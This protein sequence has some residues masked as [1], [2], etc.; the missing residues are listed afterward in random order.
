MNIGLFKKPKSSSVATTLYFAGI[1]VSSCALYLL[2][3]RPSQITQEETYCIVGIT[4]LIGIVAINLVARS[5]QQTVV[6][7]DRKKE[8]VTVRQGDSVEDNSQ[9]DMGAI[10]KIVE[11]GHEIPQTVINEL[12]HQ[13]QAGQGAVYV[14]NNQVLE[15][16]YGYALSRERDATIAYAFGK[17]LIGRVAAEGRTLYIDK[18]PEGYV[19]IF[20]GLGSASPSHLVIVPV[21]KE[22]EIR[23][24]IEI[25]TFT[26]LN[27]R[28][29]RHLENAG[30]TLA[31]VIA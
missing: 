21:K 15:L 30:E 13:L 10:K 7:L 9:I 12:C 22:N 19:T 27:E 25:A 29:I 4:F 26:P 23:G 17:G 24:V 20:S 18:L 14:T 5:K 2:P 28:T 11:T 31:D 6:Y 3:D 8:N 16:R 1:V